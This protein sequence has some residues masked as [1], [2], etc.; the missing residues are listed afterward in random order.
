[1]SKDKRLELSKWLKSD[2]KS[3]IM[4]NGFKD[5]IAFAKEQGWK[6]AK[7]VTK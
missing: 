7:K 3:T 6:P 4:L 5:T 2:G 1:M